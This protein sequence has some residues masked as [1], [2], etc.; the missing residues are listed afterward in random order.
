MKNCIRIA[1][2]GGLGDALLVTPSF[3]AL[4]EKYPASSIIVYCKMKAHLEIYQRNPYINAIRP[5][6][7]I[8]YW[9][10]LLK[11]INFCF[12]DYGN[13]NPSKYYKIG[14][15]EIIAEM[16]DVKLTDTRLQVFISDDEYQ[17]ANE[18]VAQYKNPI[19]I[20]PTS[21]TTKNQE[22]LI[23]RWEKIVEELPDYTFLQLGLMD[24]EPIKGAIDLRGKLTVREV[25]AVFKYLKGYVGVE[26]FF[27]HLA[28]AAD[29]PAVILF[30]PSN[31]VIWGHK[32]NRNIY[33]NFSCSPCIDILLK[34]PCPYNKSCM[35]NISANHVKAAIVDHIGV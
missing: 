4:K 15:S 24:E 22:W 14:A 32:S 21:R 30:G 17:R 6:K 7:K 33:K 35:A 5:L 31:P 1:T 25:M 10:H 28:S 18:F 2:W 16:L 3:K 26:S 20:N 34:T 29:I 23:D 8:H 13:L 12:I 11:L 27:G 19:G 9:L